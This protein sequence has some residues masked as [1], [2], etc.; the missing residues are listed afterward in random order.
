MYPPNSS[1][2]LN[3]FKNFLKKR[4]YFKCNFHL[5]VKYFF[6]YSN[7][8]TKTLFPLRCDQKNETQPIG[9]YYRLQLIFWF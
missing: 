5:L 3:Y 7:N 2:K 1:G 8:Y 4:S 6:D 9:S